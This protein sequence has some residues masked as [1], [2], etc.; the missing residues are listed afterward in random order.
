MKNLLASLLCCA[1]LLPGLALAE[2]PGD[3]RAIAGMD[4]GRIL[5]DITIGEPERLIA[6]L[7]VIQETYEDM[8]RQG[9]EPDMVFAFRGGAA[10]LIARDTDHLEIEDV[11]A[12]RH[13]HERLQ[14]LMELD[15][16]HMEACQIATRRFDLGQE[17]LIPGVQL[18]GNTFLSIMGYEN[19]GYTTIRID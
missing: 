11:S 4:T 13:I 14:A 15:G 10:A 1:L 18:V 8:Q 6:R 17:D 16:I 19:Q 5:W 7:S 12:A 3:Q 2:K 9:L